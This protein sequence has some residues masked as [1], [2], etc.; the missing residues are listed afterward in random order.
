M[1]GSE[2][3]EATEEK[4]L[5]ML[6]QASLKPSKQCA[7]AAKAANFTLGQIQR[8]FHNR[9]KRYL[10]PIY[11]TLVSPRLEF[12]VAAWSP[13]TENDASIMEKVQRRLVRML[14]DARGDTYE[15]KLR[16]AGLTTR[17]VQND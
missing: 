5:G 1:N 6:I 12:A 8:S 10:V 15:E 13:W 2:I 7:A 9:T 11:K 14:S 3:P 16:D 17:R 4:D